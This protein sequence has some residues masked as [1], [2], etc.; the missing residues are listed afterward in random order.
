M[1][2]PEPISLSDA[3]LGQVMRLAEPLAPHDRS[4]FLAA[5]ALLLRSEPQPPGDGVVFRS[6]RQLLAS[7]LYARQDSFAV[8]AEVLRLFT[9]LERTSKYDRRN[10]VFQAR[11]R[12]LARL[13]GLDL[14]LICDCRSVLERDP[15]PVASF[16]RPASAGQARVYETR[17]ALIAACRDAGREAPGVRPQAA[18]GALPF[19]EAEAKKRQTGRPKAG[20]EKSAPIGAQLKHRAADD[21]AAAFGTSPRNIQAARAREVEAAD[22]ANQPLESKGKRS[23]M[24][25]A[26]AIQARA[27]EA[28][29][30]ANLHYNKRGGI[31]QVDRRKQKAPSGTSAAAAMRRLRKDRP[32]IH[33]RVLAGEM[34][35]HAGMVEAGF[36]KRRRAPAPP[37]APRQA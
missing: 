1:H 11:D 17:L 28:A 7:G 20:E 16:E 35:A 18:A 29:D 30:F 6:A 34:S 26:R 23:D 12:E 36:R 5:L 9:E 25:E 10:D 2:D 8:G 31:Q 32:G 14:E 3:A 21:A 22:L 15:P 27:V 33:A 4:A 24:I 19:Y 37:I 13:L